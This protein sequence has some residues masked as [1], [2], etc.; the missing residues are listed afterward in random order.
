MEN[1]RL[2]LESVGPKIEDFVRRMIRDAGL[3]LEFS[4][5]PAEN[6]LPDFENPDIVVRFSGP[7]VDMLLANKAELLLAMEQLTMEMLRMTP[8][9]HSLLQF[10]ANDYRALRIQE[11]RLSALTAA[12][13]VKLSR[14]PFRF[15]PMTSRERRIIHLALRN[16][17][18]VRSESLGSGSQ[19]QVVIYPA[20]MPSLPEPPRQPSSPHADKR[21]RA[22]VG[23]K[24]PARSSRSSA[25][26]PAGAHAGSQ[27]SPRQNRGRHRRKPKR[28]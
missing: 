12:E 24:P 15:N 2:T 5:G 3:D 9:E 28:S 25:G 20:G 10:D 19:R 27:R 22:A 16:D 13:K 23:T 17:T 7:D 1:K 14:T 6:P 4:I 11:L 26:R 18:E 21:D 8:E